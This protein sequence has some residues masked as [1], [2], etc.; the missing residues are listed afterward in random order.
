MTTQD[1]ALRAKHEA[2]RA[3]GGLGF[4]IGEFAI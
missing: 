2:A 1:V 4:G 3:D